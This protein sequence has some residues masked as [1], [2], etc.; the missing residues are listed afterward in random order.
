MAISEI[1]NNLKSKRL[2]LG[3]S[4][5]LKNIKLGKLSK[6]FLSSNCPENVRKDVDYYSGIGNCSVENLQIPND[7]L[8]VICKKLFSVSV[9]GLLKQ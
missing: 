9:V 7:E 2:V 4:L 8:G 1:R 3:T 6:V 5:T